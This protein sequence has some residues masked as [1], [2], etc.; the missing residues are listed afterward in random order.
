MKLTSS[1]CPVISNQVFIEK[2]LGNK[3]FLRLAGGKQHLIG[4]LLKLLPSSV[5]TGRY[6]EPFMGGGSLFFATAPS[7]ARLSDANPLL[8]EMYRVLR[9][10]PHAVHGHLIRLAEAHS[11][12][13]PIS[14]TGSVQC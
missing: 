4:T 8:M 9:D 5:Q 13:D 2:D 10:D 7:E 6:I 14:W 3:S 11:K 1:A 12:V